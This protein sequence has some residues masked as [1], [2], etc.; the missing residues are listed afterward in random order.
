MDW[1]HG[2]WQ[3]IAAT[4]TGETLEGFGAKCCLERDI[5]LPIAVRAGCGGTWQWLLYSG[6]CDIVISG[7]FPNNV[8]QLLQEDLGM[9]QQW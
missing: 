1:L 4:L 6:V 2:G 3:K 5:V 8:L 7:K 9:E